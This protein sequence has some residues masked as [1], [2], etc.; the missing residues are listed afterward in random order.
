MA[1][2]FSSF[3]ESVHSA[4]DQYIKPTSK[5]FQ[6]EDKQL[7]CKEL[8]G[9]GGFSHVY[10][11]ED[12]DHQLYAVKEMQCKMKEQFIIAKQEIYAL[13]LF[14]H[15]HI[16][17]LEHA[18]ITD[19][20][21]GGKLVWL[22][23]PYY[24]RGT[25][26]DLLEAYHMNDQHFKER[27][28][29]RLILDISRAL[30]TMHNYH[31]PDQNQPVPWAHNDIKPGNIVIADNGKPLLMDF[32]SA[33]PAILSISSKQEAT[34]RQDRA[35][36][37]SSMPYRSPELMHVQ[38]TSTLD[39]KVDVWSLGCTMFAMAYGAS[40]FEYMLDRQGGGSLS[41]A[42]LNGK[43]LFPPMPSYSDSFKELV[44]W[45]ITVNA[46]QRPTS[47][48]VRMRLESMLHKTN[49]VET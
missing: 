25:L 40:P 39:A 15:D 48:E 21:K 17:P 18:A 13:R 4:L 31:P 11:A 12:T 5:I 44:S 47:S 32:G 29:L 41:L 49:Q 42:V 1:S 28:I 14:V 10:L 23:M 8:L 24:E 27:Q 2:F 35:E 38:E 3:K 7:Y 22:A 9:Q 34:Q 20:A 46:A 33:A 19:D 16:V 6:F 43:F 45:M 26:Q 37:H 30:E 36:E